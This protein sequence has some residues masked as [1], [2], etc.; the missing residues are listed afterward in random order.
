MLIEPKKG[1]ADLY[2]GNRSYPVGGLNASTI[3]NNVC[4]LRARVPGRGE[5]VQQPNS[6]DA[7]SRYRAGD[8]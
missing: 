1:G 4:G 7:L 5:R 2:T 3:Q 6:A 8:Y